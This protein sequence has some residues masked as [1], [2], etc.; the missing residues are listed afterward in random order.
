MYWK[1]SREKEP[2]PIGQHC[3][4]DSNSPA[5]NMI[6]ILSLTAVYGRFRPNAEVG[7]TN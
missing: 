7:L 4:S 1:V 6:V 3:F 2:E 5:K